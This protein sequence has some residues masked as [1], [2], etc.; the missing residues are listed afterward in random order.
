MV[1]TIGDLLEATE[2][3]RVE[4]WR[5]QSLVAAG[6]SDEVAGELAKRDADYD[7]MIRM[8]NKG[9]SEYLLLR[10]FREM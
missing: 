6:I 7:R 10:I 8:F 3:E 5:R 4:A 2:P 9:C 1:E